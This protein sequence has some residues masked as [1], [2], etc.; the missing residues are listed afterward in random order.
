MKNLGSDIRYINVKMPELSAKGVFFVGSLGFW[1]AALSIIL[2]ALICWIAFRK[3]AARKADVAGTKNRKATKMA[4]KRLQLAGTFLKQNLYTAFY[5]ELHKA[6]LGFISD[7]LNMPA[8]EL[9]RDR[10]SQSLEERGV[11]K[12]SVETFIGILDAC[13]FARYSPD[14]GNEAMAAHYNSAIE[15]I[16]SID[17]NMKS[18][19]S[20]KGTLYVIAA[21]L[22]SV[23]SIA[24]A[25]NEYLD[26]LWNGANTAYSEGRWDD[27]LAGYDMI[28][29]MGL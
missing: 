12:S 15:V 28:S 2:A 27:A 20:V 8:A 3:I 21:L 18:S 4:M 25:Q 29:G 5:E 10:I 16:S 14:S 23:P 26:S 17:S 6:L 11:D 1:M 19:K 7:K 22:L 9:S 13:E 24:S